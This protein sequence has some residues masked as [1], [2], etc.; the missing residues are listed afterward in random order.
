M[1]LAVVFSGQGMQHPHMLPWL[2]ADAT[3]QC[4]Q[5]HLGVDDW[6]GALA[7]PAWAMVNRHA[8]ILLTVTS[9][10]AWGQL[11]PHLPRPVAMAGYSVGELAAGSA[12]GMFGFDDATALAADRAQLMDVCARQHPGG[13]MA[14]SGLAAEATQTL[15]A[16]TGLSVAICNGP[17]A[18]VL[19]G[20][21]AALDRASRL[22]Q[23][24]GA[25]VTRLRVDLAS[26]TPAMHDAVAAL[27]PVL[28]AIPWQLPALP[29]CTHQGDRITRVDQARH[30]LARQT[31]NTVDWYA[32]M[33][34]VRSR[35]PGCVLQVGP[36]ASLARL[37]NQTVPDIP[38]RS[39]DEFRSV[40]AIVRWVGDH[41]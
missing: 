11:S 27:E 30:A 9:L 35:Q 40:E 8:Q 2:Q 41:D 10:A 24:A 36:G 21:A 17:Q 32:C 25:H 15:C 19:G 26:H 3:S 22:A 16:Q 4:L 5:R 37:W 23:E 34:F 18:V 38:A 39:V 6:R 33:E 28:R 7:D 12:A 14:V 1:T 29:L 20:T 13:L 31:A